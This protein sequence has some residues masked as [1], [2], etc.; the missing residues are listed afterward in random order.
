MIL[1]KVVQELI[2]IGHEVEYKER[3]DGSLRIT[4][5]DGQKY[6]GST[7]NAVGRVL[8]GQSL[9][10]AQ[11]KHLR[12]IKTPKGKFG[13]K[14]QTSILT[15]E[16]EAKFKK[17]QR[18]WRKKVKEG[19]LK[20]KITKKKFR[21]IVKKEGK[22]EALKKLDRLE[23]YVKGI[24]TDSTIDA[25]IINLKDLKRIAT[26]EEKAEIQKIINTIENKRGTIKDKDVVEISQ[27]SYNK[28]LST[29]ER[30]RRI[31]KILN[32]Q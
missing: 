13:H 6:T 4:K 27:L 11:K 17:I 23:K 28:S 3:P 1:K 24:A 16:E 26:K 29:E 18:Q 8:T 5:L 12:E 22:K 15:P 10:T 19:T 32:I 21:E 25:C 14:K 30:I 2:K 20:G 9:S 7:G 31:K